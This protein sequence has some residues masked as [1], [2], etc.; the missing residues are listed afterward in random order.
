MQIIRDIPALRVLRDEWRRN[1]EVIA[2][3]PTMGNLHDGHLSLMQEARRRGDRIIA[4]IYINPLQFDRPDDLSN[5]PR[6]LDDDIKQLRDIGV[7]V[8]FTPDDTVIYPRGIATSTTVDV[9]G[10]TG[11]LCG[12]HRA[13]HFVGVATVVC[14]LFN[15]VQPHVAI[16][17]KKDY[18]QLLV[19]KRMVADL[20]LPV[21]IIGAPTAR[22]ENGLAMSSRNNYLTEEEREQGAH[23]YRALSSITEDL[24]HGSR[25][26]SR[27]ELDAWDNLKLAGFA[28]DYVSILRADDLSAPSP[29][30][31]PKDLVV[32]AAAQLGNARLIDNLI[33]ADYLAEKKTEPSSTEV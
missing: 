19:V 24:I 18:Q 26:Y 6:T 9:P 5:Y 1:G 20:N 29:S 4:S 13:G 27:L 21:K 10:I 3:V 14:K 15:M 32:L 7:N 30:C 2:F 28:P 33:I 17:G 8:L 11:I 12:A 23:I 22:E 31:E 25:D 16:F